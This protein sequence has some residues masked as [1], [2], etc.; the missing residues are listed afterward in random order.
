VIQRSPTEDF[1]EHLQQAAA[2]V[3][4]LVSLLNGNASLEQ[5]GPVE[6]SLLL[7]ELH[8]DG[9]SIVSSRPHDSGMQLGV[10]R[11]SGGIPQF[12]PIE[13]HR[14][15]V[16]LPKTDGLFIAFLGP[17]GVG[18]TTTVDGVTEHLKPIFGE[19]H[20]FHWRPQVIKPRTQEEEE[21]GNDDGWT[22]INRHGDPPRGAWLSTMRLGGIY[23]DYLVGQKRL[24]RPALERGGLVV[25]DRY[26]PDILVDSK[27]YRYGGPQWLLEAIKM[28]LP[29]RRVFFVVLDADEK[30]ILSRKQEVS[31][32]ELRSQRRKYAALARSLHCLHIRTDFGLE[33]TLTEVL[34]G[35]GLHLTHRFD[36][37]LHGVEHKANA[38]DGT[39]HSV[40][41]AKTA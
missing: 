18:K 34:R 9:Y 19:Q 37:R 5:C 15:S 3:G 32:E 23:S 35:I 4:A 40:T 38:A 13:L 28:L 11:A 39:A 31:F 26:Y 29:Q 36:E 24:I 41:V 25:F 14:S 6:F 2:S 21:I 20:L 10:M 8:E 30:V 7:T 16:R 22:S 17:D 27:R 12:F 1:I 33:Q